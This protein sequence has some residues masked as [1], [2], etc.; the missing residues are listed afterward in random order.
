MKSHRVIRSY[1][2]FH[3]LFNRERPLLGCLDFLVSEGSFTGEQLEDALV[4]L[5]DREP[6]PT[7]M[8]VVNIVWSSS[9]LP[10]E[11]SCPFAADVVR[12]GVDGWG[13]RRGYRQA[14]SPPAMRSARCTKSATSTGCR[15]PPESSHAEI[16]YPSPP[17]PT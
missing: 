5:Q 13:V 8:R 6:E 7:D 9:K 2:S 17:R 11:N 1:D 15:Q 4:L 16:S 3:P 10:T 12:V 14:R